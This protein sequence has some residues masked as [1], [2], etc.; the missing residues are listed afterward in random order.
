LLTERGVRTL[1][2]N[3]PRYKGVYYGN[4]YDRDEAFHQGTVFPWI[5][6][7][8]V[9]GYLGV[10]KHGKLSMI[11]RYYEGF[12][13]TITEHGLG[14]ISELYDGNPPHKPGGAISQAV[15]VAEL[16]RAKFIIQKYESENPII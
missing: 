15:S 11:K 8:F 16:L 4:Q 2:P 3:D 6:G 7:H 13:E 10:H 1:S 12:E 9:E 5:F 14:T